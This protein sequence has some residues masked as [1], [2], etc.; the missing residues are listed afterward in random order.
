VSFEE[1][2]ATL[3]ISQEAARSRHF[4]AKGMLR[5][6]LAREIDLAEGDVFEFGGADCDAVV[7][8]VLARLRD[9]P[10]NS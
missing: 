5:E 1:I 9:D 8:T 4:R 10:V 3:G 6:S 7:A 2:A